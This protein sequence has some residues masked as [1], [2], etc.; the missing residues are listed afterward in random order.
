VED[1]DPYIEHLRQTTRELVD[2]TDMEPY[3]DVFEAA[4][5][6]NREA[7]EHHD[8]Q[9]QRLQDEINR[10]A[11]HLGAALAGAWA[12]ATAP[13]DGASTVKTPDPETTVNDTLP[14]HVLRLDH[15]VDPFTVDEL[16]QPLGLVTATVHADGP[17]LEHAFA[18][19][20]RSL[21]DRHYR[22]LRTAM[23]D[24]HR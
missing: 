4:V 14:P 21:P 24:T 8:Q 7:R 22:A 12:T 9:L 10:R 2:A 19:L 16:G 18:Q 6:A 3:R 13:N 20:L 11:A 15:H 1:L 17:T 5:A 23:E